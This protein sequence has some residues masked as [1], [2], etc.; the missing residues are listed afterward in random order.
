LSNLTTIGELL[1]R[2][3]ETLNLS[4]TE[5]SARLHYPSPNLVTMLE[6]GTCNIPLSKVDDVA[7]AYQLGSDFTLVLMKYL[8][9]EVWHNAGRTLDEGKKLAPDYSREAIDKRI[10]NCLRKKLDE[11]GLGWLP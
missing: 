11:F 1:K 6:A 2:Q 8:H 3:R 4:P 10:D 9:P 7:K 5:I